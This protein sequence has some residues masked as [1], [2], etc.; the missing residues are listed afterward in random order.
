MNHRSELQR[1]V[2]NVTRGDQTSGPLNYNTEAKIEEELP[3]KE[4]EI[5]VDETK[6]RRAQLKKV[7]TDAEYISWLDKEID[8]ADKAV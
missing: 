7:L 2:E 3:G 8:K 1:E 4:A 6:D 5:E